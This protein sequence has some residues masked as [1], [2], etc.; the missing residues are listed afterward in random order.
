MRP[1]TMAHDLYRHCVAGTQAGVR[2]QVLT[3]G[4]AAAVMMP[5]ILT[6]RDTL[7]D[8]SQEDRARSGLQ[9]VLTV[10]ATPSSTA[11]GAR[12]YYSNADPIGGI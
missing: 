9:L 5:G 1:S 3:L 11:A 10:Y 6:S 12:Q 7:S 8:C 4:L 2:L